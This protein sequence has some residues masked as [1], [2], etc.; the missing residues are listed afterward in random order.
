MPMNRQRTFRPELFTDEDL[1]ELP[2]PV[3]VTAWGLR[4][5]A[6]DHGRESTTLSRIKGAL[7]AQDPDVDE[8]AVESHLLELAQIGYLDLYTAGGRTYFAIRDWTRV[9]RPQP[10]KIPAP[11]PRERIAKASRSDRV[12]F[13]VGEGASE[14]ESESEWAS[15]GEVP[16]RGDRELPPSPFCPT[17]YATQGTDEDCRACGRRRLAAQ[18]WFRNR[19]SPS[20]PIPFDLR[21]NNDGVDYDVETPY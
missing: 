13:A 4:M 19:V 7:W 3:R 20:A 11:P 10:S 15:A 2:L 9:D 5:F 17:H 12:T 21:S 8:S 1:A 14:R 16:A 6:D 18:E